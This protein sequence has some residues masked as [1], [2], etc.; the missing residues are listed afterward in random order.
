MDKDMK[1]GFGLAAA[2]M[3]LGFVAAEPANGQDFVATHEWY[4]LKIAAVTGEYCAEPVTVVEAKT[5]AVWL[6][7]QHT[8]I[9]Y[10]LDV[11]GHVYSF[12]NVEHAME[13]RGFYS[14]LM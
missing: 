4:A 9:V 13:M 2:V 14:N 3:L 6:V 11:D 8:P 10:V 7:C 5:A 12:D 1:I